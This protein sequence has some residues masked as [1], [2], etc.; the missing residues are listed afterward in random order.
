[1]DLF[2]S[3]KKD[4]KDTFH[5]VISLSL[6][7]CLVFFF[8]LNTNF[9]CGINIWFFALNLFFLFFGASKCIIMVVFIMK[10]Q[11]QCNILKSIYSAR[12]SIDFMTNSTFNSI[13]QLNFVALFP[14]FRRSLVFCIEATDWKGKMK[15]VVAWK[16]YTVHDVT[17]ITCSRIKRMIISKLYSI[18][19]FVPG[20]PFRRIPFGVSGYNFLPAVRDK[21]E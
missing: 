2:C 10:S 19:C 12:F 9:F 17:G 21:S 16:T 15:S 1:M 13:I 4:A 7:F 8:I 11:I 5:T 18:F 6:W 20:I 3:R 14:S